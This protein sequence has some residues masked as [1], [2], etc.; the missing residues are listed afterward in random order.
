LR[1]PDA[2]LRFDLLVQALADAEAEFILIGGWA[3]ILN[4]SVRT[5]RD[6]DVCYARTTANCQRIAAA[7]APFRPRLREIPADVPFLWDAATLRNGTLFT[8]AT[9]AGSIDLLSEVR[10]LGTYEDV[11]ASSKLVSAFDRQIRTLDLRGLIAAKRAAGRPKDIEA[12]AELESLL[13][14]SED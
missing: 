13:E 7:L 10:G 2:A 5:T 1:T 12:L 14:A 3:A 9:T 6:L 8:L 4:G 11:S